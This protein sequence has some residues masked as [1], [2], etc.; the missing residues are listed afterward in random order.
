[1]QQTERSCKIHIS[2][3]FRTLLGFY[4]LRDFQIRLH[5]LTTVGLDAGFNTFNMILDNKIIKLTFK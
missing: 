5:H 4:I 2:R 1:M 3:P